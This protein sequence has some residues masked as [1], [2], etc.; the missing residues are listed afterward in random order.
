MLST[1]C[2]S[3]LS[4]DFRKLAFMT[5]GKR[6]KQA[7]ELA[8]TDRAA[9]AADLGVSVQAVGQVITG[10]RN[11]TQTFTASNNVKAARFL[12]VDPLWLATGEGDMV[13]AN[14]WP[15]ALLTP[16]DVRKLSPKALEIVERQA[17]SLLDLETTAAVHKAQTDTVAP[18]KSE[19]FP[20]TQQKPEFMKAVSG[21]H[22]AD[23][24]TPRKTGNG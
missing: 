14:V 10:G 7:I 5:Y 18:P 20:G 2:A 8:G 13:S 9:L 24:R 23:P 15:F 1:T 21:K 19:G 16:D 22:S 3:I 4:S 11:G 12:R 6:L 17:I